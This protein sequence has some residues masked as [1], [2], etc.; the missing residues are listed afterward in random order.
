M[1]SRSSARRPDQAPYSPC[2]GQGVCNPGQ[3]GGVGELSEAVVLLGKGEMAL[4]GSAGDVLVPVQ[5]DLCSERRM[6]RHLDRDVPPLGIHDVEGIVIDVRQLLG[7]VD[8]TA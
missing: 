2:F 1:P 8:A 7:Q 3:V 4:G 6:P 5:D